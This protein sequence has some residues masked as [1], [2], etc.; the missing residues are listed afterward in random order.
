MGSDSSFTLNVLSLASLSPIGGKD[1][2]Y[3]PVESF[4]FK[5]SLAFSS[6]ELEAK[7]SPIKLATSSSS[8]NIIC[9]LEASVTADLVYVAFSP[10]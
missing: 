4:A 6:S 9:A 3:S 5:T 7:I 1:T 10:L 8:K 2:V